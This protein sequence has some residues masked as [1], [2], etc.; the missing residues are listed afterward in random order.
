MVKTQ[1]LLG[2]KKE[3]L[4]GPRNTSSLVLPSQLRA[5]RS[6]LFYL[7]TNPEVAEPGLYSNVLMGHILD[8]RCKMKKISRRWG[9]QQPGD[10]FGYHL[11]EG[12]L[13]NYQRPSTMS[14]I[15]HL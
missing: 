2:G 7:V 10:I 5:S 15:S 12:A 1:P 9:A 11:F 8:E 3:F 14:V 4:L 13:L 6:N